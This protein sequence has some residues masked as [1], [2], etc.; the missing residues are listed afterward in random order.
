MSTSSTP[1][2]KPQA[3]AID[4]AEDSLAESEQKGDRM[5]LLSPWPAPATLTRSGTARRAPASAGRPTSC[6]GHSERHDS[7]GARFSAQGIA[8]TLTGRRPL[9]ALA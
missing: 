9:G 1:S 4:G 8:A 3:P 5:L 6:F 2:L 7:L